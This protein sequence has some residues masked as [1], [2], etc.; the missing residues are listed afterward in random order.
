M[1]GIPEQI[2]SA[3]RQEVRFLDRLSKEKLKMW[4]DSAEVGCRSK[5]EVELETTGDKGT[6]YLLQPFS[7]DGYAVPLSLRCL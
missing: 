5:G 7:G 4:T 3:R 6:A 1:D 2:F